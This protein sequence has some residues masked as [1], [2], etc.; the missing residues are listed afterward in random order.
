M[1]VS[2]EIRNSS[3]LFNKLMCLA[4]KDVSN[5]P[6]IINEDKTKLYVEGFLQGIDV[7]FYL[8]QEL[9]MSDAAIHEMTRRTKNYLA[10]F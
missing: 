8:M 9:G 7:M 10:A 6:I 3:T 4:E 2:T 5:H 1:Q